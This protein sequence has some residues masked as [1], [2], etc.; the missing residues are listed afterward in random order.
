MSQ[1]GRI[2]YQ[3]MD[4]QSSASV[5]SFYVTSIMDVDHPDL[6]APEADEGTGTEEKV[7]KGGVSIYMAHSL[8]L[9]FFS[10]ANGKS[11][12]AKMKEPSDE[13]RDVVSLEVKQQTEET[14]SSSAKSSPN[15]PPQP[16]CNWREVR[17]SKFRYQI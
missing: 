9:L 7:G 5:G 17:F 2:Y 1:A 15:P 8:R 12:A 16:L 4:A 10:Y 13:L 6:K 3:A 11:F 14:S